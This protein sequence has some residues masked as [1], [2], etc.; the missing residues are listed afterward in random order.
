VI[1]EPIV[2]IAATGAAGAWVGPAVVGGV[3]GFVDYVGGKASVVRDRI[4]VVF[5]YAAVISFAELLGWNPWIRSQV[6]GD[7]SWRMV[8]AVA[9]LITH[10]CLVVVWLGWPK[11]WA[12]GLSKRLRFASS[13]SEANKINQTL[14]GWTTAAALTAPLSGDAGWGH[15]VRLIGEWTTATPGHVVTWL[16]H[17]L[18]G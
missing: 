3:G 4:A 13:D 12:K 8:G 14:L 2:T 17:W 15:I 10:G 1:A 9:S 6:G 11:Q 5:Y 16:F 7:Y 18:G